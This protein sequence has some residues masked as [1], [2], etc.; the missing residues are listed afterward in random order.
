MAH[1]RAARPKAD[2]EGSGQPS[3][4]PCQSTQRLFNLVAGHVCSP[5]QVFLDHSRSFGGQSSSVIALSVDGRSWRG[6]TGGGGGG[7]LSR[8]NDGIRCGKEANESRPVLVPCVPSPLPAAD[9]STA[10]CLTPVVVRLQCALVDLACRSAVSAARWLC[11]MASS[12]V[13]T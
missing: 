5:S 2:C 10:A 13:R 11:R 3:F 6:R 4:S 7:G 1:A 9:C 8:T 12:A